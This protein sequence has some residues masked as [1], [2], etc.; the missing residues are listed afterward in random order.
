MIVLPHPFDLQGDS[1]CVKVMVA[2]CKSRRAEEIDR[3]FRLYFDGRVLKGEFVY[4]VD[5]QQIATGVRIP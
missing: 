5:S 4:V 3:V 2:P 1:H